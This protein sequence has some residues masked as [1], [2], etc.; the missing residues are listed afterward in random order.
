MRSSGPW[1]VQCRLPFVLVSDLLFFWVVISF[2]RY[3]N[4]KHNFLIPFVYYIIIILWGGS[5]DSEYRERAF[6]GHSP[7][8]LSLREAEFA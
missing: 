3:G 2:W 6:S 8:A 4:W 7:R 5:S 1:L